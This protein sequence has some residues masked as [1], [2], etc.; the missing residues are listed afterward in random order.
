MASVFEAVAGDADY[1]GFVFGDAALLD[2]LGGYAC[3][4]AA[5]GF[6]KMP[7]VWASSLMESMISG[8]EMSSDQ[9]PDSRMSS[10][11]RGRRRDCR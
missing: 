1:R 7:S 8:S 10:E 11:R 3:G 6:G 9:P 2:E 4:Y 5:G